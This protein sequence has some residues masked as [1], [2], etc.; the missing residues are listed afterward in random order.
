MDIPQTILNIMNAL[1]G[2]SVSGEN[3]LNRMLAAIHTLRQVYEEITTRKDGGEDVQSIGDDDQPV[4][5]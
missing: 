1:E 3:N 4:G 5:R 2:V